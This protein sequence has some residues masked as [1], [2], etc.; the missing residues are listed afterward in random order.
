MANAIPILAVMLLAAAVSACSEKQAGTEAYIDR[1][2]T[3]DKLIDDCDPVAAAG[4][5]GVRFGMTLAEAKAVFPEPLESF[6]GDETGTESLSCFMV[7][8]ESR[9]KDL[10]FMLVDGRVARV[11][12]FLSG[13]ATENGS[14]V[15][16]FEADIL[17]RYGGRAKVLP[18]KYDDAKR[19]IVV[20]TSPNHQFIFES[21]GSKILNYRAG[22]LPPVGY[23]EGCS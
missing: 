11:D 21:D 16:S 15:G 14:Q 10:T 12:I 5:C 2:L 20:S 8:P 22:V 13:I 6:G 23:V 3:G 18:N 7:F 17:A 19:D 4:F 1:M 9:S